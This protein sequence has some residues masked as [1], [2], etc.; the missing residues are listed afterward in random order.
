MIYSA[1]ISDAMR[2]A[3]LLVSFSAIGALN[4][5]AQPEVMGWGNLE[6]IRVNGHLHGFDAGLCVVEP[7]WS[8][9]SRTGKERQQTTFLRRGS[10]V[11]ISLTE[12]RP[13]RRLRRE[14]AA[15]RFTGNLTV[16]A[17]EPGAARVSV[18]IGTAAGAAVEGVF[19]C[20]QLPATEFSRGKAEL[21]GASPGVPSAVSLQPLTEE[22]NE[23]LRATASGIRLA[24]PA[25][26]LEIESLEPVE[27][28]IRDD[29]RE[30]GY[31]LQVM[32]RLLPANPA[33]G[34]SASASFRIRAAGDPDVR[35]VRVRF[36]PAKP[37]RMWHGF[38]GNFRIQ[39]EKRDLPVI[40][41]NLANL[42]LAWARVDMP[43]SLWDPEEAADPL[44]QARAGRLHPRVRAAMLMAQRLHRM[45]LPVIASAWFPPA[46]AVLGEIKRPAEEDGPRGNPLNPEKMQR[47]SASLTGYFLF[48]KEEFGVEAA[49]FSFNESDLGIDVR[50]TPREH[51]LLIRTLG[52][53]FARHGLATRL[54]AGDTSDANPV[55]FVDPLLEDPEAARFAG[56]VSFHSW[57]GCT[58]ENLERWLDAARRLNVPL[59]VG[60]GSTDAAAWRYS[61]IFLEPSFALYEIDLYTRILALAQPASILQWQLT[62]D[63]SLLAGNGI[64]G[65]DGPLRPTQRFWNLRQLADTPHRSFHL[66]VE[67]DH[68]LVTAAALGDIAG[69][70][71]TIHLVN[72]GAAR[73]AVI[74]GFPDSVTELRAW[75][76]DASRSMQELGR[77]PVHQGTAAL[78]LD[79]TSFVTL[80]SAPR[81]R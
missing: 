75:I 13:P 23:Y 34:A 22:Q 2:R 66:P 24:A 20:L 31:D 41:Y 19:Y 68:P 50:Q 77:I 74:E 27:I 54:L 15:W 71:F 78:N 47:I 81:A 26:T 52:P 79:A 40:D 59:L 18:Q 12:F 30:G 73:Q 10:A 17:L 4:A 49:L 32:F 42:P 25:R 43:W 45:G 51:T 16:E 76:T 55:A 5:A 63:Y 14:G 11:E 28:V 57:R 60:E 21:L 53:Y 36:D 44:A 61:R 69:G 46:W 65:D 6:G 9:W 7:G 58:K 1:E 29:R 35:P 33:A 37:G 64:A 70:V 67:A 72:R 39:N 56:A 38:G 62:A 48:L 80:I 8:A 3:I